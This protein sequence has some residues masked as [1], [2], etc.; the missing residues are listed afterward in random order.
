M[1]E[2]FAQAVKDG[3]VDYAIELLK[4]IHIEEEEKDYMIV[5][6]NPDRFSDDEYEWAYKEWREDIK[7]G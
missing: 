1:E 4:E 5:L 6:A 3:D 7:N 2:E